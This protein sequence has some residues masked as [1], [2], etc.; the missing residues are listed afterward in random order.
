LLTAAQSLFAVAILVNLEITARE[1]V[2]LSGLFLAQF[3]LGAVVPGGSE[4]VALAA[5][6]LALAAALL[7]R[8]RRLLGPLLRD[9]LRTSY[10]Q[11]QQD[12]AG[13]GR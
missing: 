12:H 2:V 3:A 6:Y 7:V 10:H 11:L 5:G 1:A 9:G 13:G 4:L 8:G